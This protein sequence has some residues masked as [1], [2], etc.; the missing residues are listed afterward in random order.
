V[1]Y[2]KAGNRIS[3]VN[4]IYRNSHHP[5]WYR[6]GFWQ[7][8]FGGVTLS[9]EGWQVQLQIKNEIAELEVTLL[10]CMEEDPAKA[11]DILRQ[12]KGNVFLLRNVDL[13]ALNAIDKDLLAAMNRQEASPEG[14]TYIS[15]CGGGCS[16]W[17]SYDDYS[18][19][20][21]SSCSGDSGSGDGG[22]GDSGCGSSCGGGCGGGD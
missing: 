16:A 13:A 11:Q 4:R 15:S 1:A 12:I 14:S 18:G 6:Q 7:Q 5:E 20:W 9:T 19:S 10:R 2:Q 22:G 3:Y 17:D 8:L 21:D